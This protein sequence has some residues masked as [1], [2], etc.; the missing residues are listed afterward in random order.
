M[1]HGGR[2]KDNER[3]LKVERFSQKRRSFCLQE[4]SQVLVQVTQRGWAVS[5]LGDFQT[6]T[7]SSLENNQNKPS[8]L[9]SIMIL[10][11]WALFLTGAEQMFVGHK[12]S[13]AIR[14][15]VNPHLNR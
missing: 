3:K 15:C 8:S 14:D 10:L 9:G 13:C 4:L 1:V 7:E 2:T 11:F 12:S 5:V 6:Q